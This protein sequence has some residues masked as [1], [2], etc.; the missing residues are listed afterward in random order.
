M[1]LIANVVQTKTLQAGESV[2]Y[3]ATY[4]ATDPTT[5]ALLPIGYADGYLRIMQGSFVNVNGHQCEI[6]GRVCMD[7]TIVKVP[8]QVKAGDS[9]ILIDNHRESPQ[10]VEVA[11]ESNILLIMKCFVT[12]RDVCRE[13]IMMVINVL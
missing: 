13:S 12:C 10:S 2:S 9:V 3:G 8:N 4:T 1:Q 5:I 6:I 7:Q 11:A